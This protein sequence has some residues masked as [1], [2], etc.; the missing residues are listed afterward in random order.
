MSGK[1]KVGLKDGQPGRRAEVSK[2]ICTR[3]KDY[4]CENC[5]DLTR[6][7]VNLG[8]ICHCKRHKRDDS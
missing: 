5:I 3:C 8:P 1:G 4:Q 7:K 6:T 2:F